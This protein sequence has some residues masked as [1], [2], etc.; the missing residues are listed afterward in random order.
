MNPSNLVPLHLPPPEGGYLYYWAACVSWTHGLT[1]T[2]RLHCPSIQW[3]C[4]HSLSSPSFHP[5]ASLNNLSAEWSIFVGGSGQSASLEWAARH[6]C[7]D[8]RWHAVFY[9]WGACMARSYSITC[10][11]CCSLC[12]IKNY[13][14]V[15][16]AFDVSSG[17]LAPLASLK[18]GAR[19][20]A[21][22]KWLFLILSSI[23]PLI[24]T[25]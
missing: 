20:C 13:M 24:W 7:A 18:W 1:T 11:C 15:E 19:S 12:F 6:S 23:H 14:L 9:R 8:R 16:G 2:I 17:K 4:L 25:L 10:F 3:D 21:H 5:Y 22:R